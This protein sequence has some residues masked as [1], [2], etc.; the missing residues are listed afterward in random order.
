MKYIIGRLVIFGVLFQSLVVYPQKGIT[1]SLKGALSLF[2]KDGYII[3]FSNR[4][5]ALDEDL[6]LIVKD[7]LTD[8]LYNPA[9]VTKKNLLFL[10]YPYRIGVI[11]PLPFDI[12]FGAFIDGFFIKNSSSKREISE[13]HKYYEEYS[14]NRIGS[15]ERKDEDYKGILIMSKDISI[16]TSFGIKYTYEFSNYRHESENEYTKY[17]KDIDDNLFIR[18]GDEY[19]LRKDKFKDKISSHRIALGTHTVSG[20]KINLD[21]IIELKKEDDKN[22]DEYDSE[23][24][25]DYEQW[26]FS[27]EDSSYRRN[28]HIRDNF[29]KESI[30]STPIVG[31]FGIRLSKE[32]KDIRR[33]G[34]CSFFWG[35]GDEERDNIEDRYSLNEFYGSYWNNTTYSR[36]D[37]LTDSIY[38]SLSVKGDRNIFAIMS[39]LGEERKILPNLMLGY[40]VR[41]FYIKDE[42]QLEG[43]KIEEDTTS[44]K[45][46]YIDR[47]AKV[48]FP[49]GFEYKPIK[50]IAI[51]VG[52]SIYGLYDFYNERIGDGYNRREI[53]SGPYFRSNS[54]LGFNIKDKFIIDVLARDLKNIKNWKVELIYNFK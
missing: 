43:E 18:E 14:Y 35:K 3:E 46:T 49:I 26:F 36:G 32:G 50:E 29:G 17:L 40:G 9:N 11:S 1:A 4:I 10:R 53:I 47:E 7:E 15:Y 24:L 45:V 8:M 38:N 41:L 31:N 30:I 48:S 20:D 21:C 22:L 44:I 42:S 51:R 52:G 19:G 23:V 13:P 12:R 16:N 2:A 27:D 34:V 37:T 39:A 5:G 25:S 54:G 33:V 28:R 6:R